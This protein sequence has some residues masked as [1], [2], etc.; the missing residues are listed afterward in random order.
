[1]PIMNPNDIT[2]VIAEHV[3]EAHACSNWAMH[4]NMNDI[5]GEIASIDVKA[6]A[7]DEYRKWVFDKDVARDYLR[8]SPDWVNIMTWTHKLKQVN[9][10]YVKQMVSDYYQKFLR[11]EFDND[12]EED[13]E[14]EDDPINA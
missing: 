4:V 10:K 9:W 8:P 13:S 6:F 1:M 3:V 12:N 11:M 14:C 5:D 7:K 2:R